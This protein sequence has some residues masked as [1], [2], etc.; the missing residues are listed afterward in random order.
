MWIT[1]ESA[2][3]DGSMQHSRCKIYNSVDADI[4]IKMTNLYT[5]ISMLGILIKKKWQ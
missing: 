3:K 1:L 4:Y 5:S 2:G